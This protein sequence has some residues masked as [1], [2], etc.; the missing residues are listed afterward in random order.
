MTKNKDPI[1]IPVT[2]KNKIIFNEGG[3]G[4]IF[5]SIGSRIFHKIVRIP[6]T[7]E[8]KKSD[9]GRTK[10]VIEYKMEIIFSIG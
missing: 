5:R 8:S 1:V 10:S 3:K 6:E 2:S 4:V 7:K 9:N